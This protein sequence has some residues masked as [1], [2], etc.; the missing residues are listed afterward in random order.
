MYEL[1]FWNGTRYAQV[2]C[3]GLTDREQFLKSAD[4]PSV[5]TGGGSLREIAHPGMHQSSGDPELEG[6]YINKESKG[7]MGE[8]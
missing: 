2:H 4:A 7:E 5:G 8:P 1:R 3:P 6:P